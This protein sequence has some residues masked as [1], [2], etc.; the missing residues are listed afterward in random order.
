MWRCCTSVVKLQARSLTWRG[1]PPAPTPALLAASGCR[2]E[3]QDAS[4]EPSLYSLPHS[5]KER[6]PS[7]FQNL[8]RGVASSS[9]AKSGQ[10]E[11]GR[12]EGRGAKRHSI[13]R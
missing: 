3:A 2:G 5:L 11:D 8:L 12:Q 6:Q 9:R 13:S 1:H 4:W 10:L 7:K